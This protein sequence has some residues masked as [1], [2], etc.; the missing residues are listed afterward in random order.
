M[1]WVEGVTLGIAVTGAVLGLINTAWALWRDRVRIRVRVAW[2][3]A[4]MS[5]DPPVTVEVVNRSYLA[6]TLVEVAWVQSSDAKRR[7]PF[8]G[9]DNQDVERTG[10][11]P[12]RL[13]A[14][15]IFTLTD[16]T[17][18]LSRD[19]EGGSLSAVI[20]R[21]ACGTVVV[22]RVKADMRAGRF[23]I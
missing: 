2:L 1:G 8:L 7:G 5:G 13:E 9:F 3:G 20:V 12:F 19:V 6:V 10:G 22:R 16:F 23:P 11:L 14:R 18:G 4:G 15:S 21:T 17:L